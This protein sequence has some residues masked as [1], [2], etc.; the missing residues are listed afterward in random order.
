MT[1]IAETAL[2]FCR[3]VMGW[4]DAEI[5]RH[6]S[7]RNIEVQ[8]YAGDGK[9]ITKRF[10]FTDLNAVMEAVRVWCKRRGKTLVL[11]IGD[12]RVEFKINGGVEII[13]GIESGNMALCRHSMRACVDLERKL[14]AAA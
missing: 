14:K 8:S 1:D 11:V 2:A 6:A 12:G 4:N 5:P 10:N 7:R 13:Y 3:E 9:F